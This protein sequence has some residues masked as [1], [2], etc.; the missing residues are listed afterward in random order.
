LSD[1]GKFIFFNVANFLEVKTVVSEQFD[2]LTVTLVE[3]PV[4]WL[5]SCVEPSL[6]GLKTR[7]FPTYREVL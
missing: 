2:K 7:S 4:P 1:L 3:L 5:V 6:S